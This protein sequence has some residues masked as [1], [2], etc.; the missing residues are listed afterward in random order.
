MIVVK[1]FGNNLDYSFIKAEKTF[2]TNTSNNTAPNTTV[3]FVEYTNRSHFG[4]IQAVF[5]DKSGKIL[6][7]KTLDIKERIPSMTFYWLFGII[8]LCIPA[9]NI[10]MII[11]IKRSDMRRKWLKYFL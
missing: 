2:G 6:D 11:L 1:N 4:M 10:Y 9:F 7:I 5:D 3:V 8:A